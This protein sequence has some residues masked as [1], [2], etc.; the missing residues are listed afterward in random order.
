MTLEMTLDRIATALERIADQGDKLATRKVEMSPNFA[1]PY[2]TD[3]MADPSKSEGTKP[4][5]E[6]PDWNPLTEAVQTRYDAK[7][8]AILEALATEKGLTFTASTTGA[9]LHQM[10]LDDAS[11]EGA[12]AKPEPEAKPEPKPKAPTLDE[13][14]TAIGQYAARRAQAKAADPK[15]DARALMAHFGGGMTK[16]DDIA[17]EHR[18]AVI[19]AANNDWTPEEDL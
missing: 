14:K 16:T 6:A 1:A 19:E 8:R 7:K 17:E 12:P 13:L 9:Q 5:A 4:A 10:L 2:G 3:P 18:A 11:G 15:S